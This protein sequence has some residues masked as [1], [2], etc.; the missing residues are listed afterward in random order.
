MEKHNMK[1]MIMIVV[2]IMA[3]CLCMAGCG[4]SDSGDNGGVTGAT[5]VI[6]VQDQMQEAVYE[7]A[8]GDTVYDI[9]M[10]TGL[11]VSAE[12]TGDGL[13]IEAIQGVANGDKG[14]T[15]GWMFTVNGET[16]MD[17]CDKVTV[18]DGDEIVWDFAEGM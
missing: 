12:D 14:K 2:T 11:A 18:N 6:T 16:P 13:S 9:L 3:V 8:E 15:S 17:Y 4:G 1:K 5:C 10:K 7:I